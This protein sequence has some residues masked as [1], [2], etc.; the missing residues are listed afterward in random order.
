MIP[1]DERVRAAAAAVPR[2]AFPPSAA[3]VLGSGLGGF[4][5]SIPGATAI[6]AG[7]IPHYPV[8]TVQ[9]HAGR[10][11]S[12]ESAGTSFLA[13]Q[14]RRHY[15][16]CGDAEQVVFPVL[17]AR[18]L[19]AHTLLLTNAA[20]GV[21]RQLHP[22]DLMVITDQINLTGRQPPLERRTGAA[23]TR[24][25][26]SPE[27]TAAILATGERLRIV[28]KKG[29]YCGVLGPTY[30][31]AA[32]VELIHRLKA[33]AVGMS[34]VLEALTASRLGMRVGGISLITNYGTGIRP[35]RLSH[36]HVTAAAGA[37]AQ[38]FEA[39]LRGVVGILG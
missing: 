18:E 9:G 29:V 20:G 25:I 38:S 39:L 8:A 1:L 14:G 10:I 36:D 22:G 23:G 34:T 6:P 26:Y 27:L 16:E 13:F 21:S 37:A 17:L 28:L 4:A 30:E 33:D 35:A 7:E 24:N 12:W 2:M 32:E 3:I 19:G 31:T 11:I 15:Y 5:D